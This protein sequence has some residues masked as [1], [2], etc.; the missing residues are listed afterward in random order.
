MILTKELIVAV[1]ATVKQLNEKHMAA[2]SAQRDQEE[3]AIKAFLA[4]HPSLR[5]AKKRREKVVAR[6]QKEEKALEDLAASVGL[7]CRF[8]YIQDSKK[9]TKAGGSYPMAPNKPRHVE[10]IIAQLAGCSDREG[11]LILKSLGINWS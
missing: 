2:K 10:M 4:V 7:G 6:L 11:K 5:A 1:R 8:S 9:F 3:K